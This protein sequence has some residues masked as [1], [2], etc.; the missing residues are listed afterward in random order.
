M[1]TSSKKA[2]FE[3][4]MSIFG[5]DILLIFLS[6]RLAVGRINILINLVDQ[7]T[8]DWNNKYMQEPI[9]SFYHVRHS[10]SSIISHSIYQWYWGISINTS[11]IHVHRIPLWLAYLRITYLHDCCTVPYVMGI[12]AL[13]SCCLQYRQ[14]KIVIPTMALFL[15]DIPQ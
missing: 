1:V 9:Y 8:S 10:S 7:R 6:F 11:T 5:G 2:L 14:E 4:V 3:E 13:L 12:Y 15:D